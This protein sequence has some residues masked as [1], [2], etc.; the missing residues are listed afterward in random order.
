MRAPSGGSRLPEGSRW[1]VRGI[2][3]LRYRSA[4]G[5]LAVLLAVG[6]VMSGC[7]DLPRPDIPS[8]TVGPVHPVVAQPAN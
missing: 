4:Q 3:A 8:L 2:G 1:A 6:V 5:G 7:R